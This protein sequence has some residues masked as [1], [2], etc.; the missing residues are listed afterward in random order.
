[1]SDRSGEVQEETPNK[2]SKIESDEA[3]E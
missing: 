2:R 3:A 1:V